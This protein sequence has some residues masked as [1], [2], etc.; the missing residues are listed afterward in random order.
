QVV[1]FFMLAYP[2]LWEKPL[3]ALHFCEQIDSDHVNN[4]SVYNA[5]LPNGGGA[6]RMR[7][8]EGLIK[9]N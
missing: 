1:S 5:S 2:Q 8:G 6:E 3:K 7:G 4:H 9:E